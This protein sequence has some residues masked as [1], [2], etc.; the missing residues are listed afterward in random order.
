MCS[1]KLTVFKT[2][3]GVWNIFGEGGGGKALAFMLEI[4]LSFCIS[5]PASTIASNRL[6]R[7]FLCSAVQWA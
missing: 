3:S 2:L 1:L 7:L 4:Y 6:Q 5:T